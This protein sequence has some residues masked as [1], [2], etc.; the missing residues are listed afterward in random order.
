MRRQTCRVR[1]QDCKVG[2]EHACRA[3]AGARGSYRARS[4][5]ARVEQLW[6]KHGV[7]HGILAAG[8]EH[9]LSVA[10][11]LRG[12]LPAGHDRLSWYKF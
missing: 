9:R 12:V 8:D 6:V 10:Q 2:R 11:R 4:A 7:S 3:G 1:R 5:S